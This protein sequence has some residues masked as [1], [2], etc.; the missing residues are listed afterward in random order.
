M[1]TFYSIVYIKPNTLTDEHIAVGVFMGGGEGPYFYLSDKRLR[2]L[3]NILHKNTF[4]S[5]Q[6][7][8]KYLKQKVDNYRKS[9]KE[10]MLFDPHY[11]QEEFSRL[12]KITK[13][14][15]RY[16]EPVSVN[17]W[18]NEE[19][20]NRFIQK[21][22]GEK[23]TKS[24]RNRPVFQFKWKAFYHSNRFLDW[25]K[26]IPINELNTKVDLTFKIDL[27]NHSRKIAVKTI[28]FNLSQVNIS[29]KKFELET[30]DQLLS[31]YKMICVYPVPVTKS[32]KSFFQSTKVTLKHITFVKFSEFKLNH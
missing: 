12:N 11:S 3:N 27:I 16:S 8:L 29:R 6:K 15:I 31:D 7:Q 2:L 14:T 13:G 4:L 23:V 28:D 5:L 26:D 19:F 25:E 18:L 20:F 17:E 32:A 30:T 9:N 1:E 22:L 10:L 24:N 21:V